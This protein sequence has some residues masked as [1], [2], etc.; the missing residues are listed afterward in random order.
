[1]AFC[2]P[3]TPLG[4]FR[5]TGQR[6]VSPFH[7]V[8]FHGVNLIA[9]KTPEFGP[10]ILAHHRHQAFVALRAAGYIHLILPVFGWGNAEGTIRFHKKAMAL[11]VRQL[12]DS[13][14]M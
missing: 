12:A 1:M 4:R 11:R 8:G 10:G 13:G 14:T 6:T 2:I 3:M 5:R 9:L 7:G